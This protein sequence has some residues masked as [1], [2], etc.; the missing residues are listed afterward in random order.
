MVVC[1]ACASDLTP[2]EEKEIEQNGKM[3]EEKE[4]REERKRGKGEE[5]DSY[6]R[7]HGR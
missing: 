1:K 5:E 2:K 7:G 4:W 6:S 3:E